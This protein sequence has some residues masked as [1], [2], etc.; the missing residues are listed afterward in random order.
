MVESETS[1][2][3]FAGMK[4]LG[5]DYFR[6]IYVSVFVLILLM[7]TVYFTAQDETLYDY[8]FH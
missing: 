3:N 2:S 1:E 5:V 8:S 7:I 4:F 6:V